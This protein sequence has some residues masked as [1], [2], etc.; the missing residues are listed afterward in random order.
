[1]LDQVLASDTPQLIAARFECA[2]PTNPDPLSLE[3]WVP[4]LPAFAPRNPNRS[5]LFP[6]PAAAKKTTS[7][8][9]VR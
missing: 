4:K 1:L 8:R 5:G 6:V 7:P 3:A 2:W 9:G